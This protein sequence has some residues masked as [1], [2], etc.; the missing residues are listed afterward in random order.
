[1]E[2]HISWA[3]LARHI[4]PRE[5]DEEAVAETPKEHRSQ[6]Q[7]IR[8]SQEHH[9]SRTDSEK[10]DNGATQAASAHGGDRS[11]Q[12]E[13]CGMQSEEGMAE[14]RSSLVGRK[15]ADAETP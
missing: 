3:S 6:A 11:S 1:M 8:H 9:K 10:T 5:Q 7:N 12:D 2:P 13:C 15:A 4:L 14:R